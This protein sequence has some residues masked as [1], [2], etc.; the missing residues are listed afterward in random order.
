MFPGILALPPNMIWESCRGWGGEEGKRYA[1][2]EKEAAEVNASPRPLWLISYKTYTPQN[3]GVGGGTQKVT[4]TTRFDRGF[5]QAS[6][7]H[8]LPPHGELFLKS[9]PSLEF[10]F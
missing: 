2:S 1:H 8:P 9:L 3:A 10:G 7:Q 6:Q 5:R 4:K